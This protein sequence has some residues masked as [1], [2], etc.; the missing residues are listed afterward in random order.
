MIN[1]KL[2]LQDGLRKVQMRRK[3]FTQILAGKAFDTFLRIIV[4]FFFFLFLRLK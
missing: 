3:L 2:D 1:I 4:C